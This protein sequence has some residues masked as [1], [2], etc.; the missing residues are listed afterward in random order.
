MR[1]FERREPVYEARI[2]PDEQVFTDPDEEEAVPVE[3]RPVTSVEGYHVVDSRTGQLLG[4]VVDDVALSGRRWTIRD[5]SDDEVAT[6]RDSGWLRALI[7]HVGLETTLPMPTVSPFGSGPR[8]S[9]S[10]DPFRDVDVRRE[11]R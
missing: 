1:R 2:E 3:D 11:A 9:A 4:R 10:E 5:E 7:Y 6:V 8:R